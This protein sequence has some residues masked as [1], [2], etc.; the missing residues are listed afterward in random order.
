[1]ILVNFFKKYTTCC[2]LILIA[3][4]IDQNNYGDNYFKNGSKKTKEKE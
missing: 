2:L 4:H 3:G 1:M